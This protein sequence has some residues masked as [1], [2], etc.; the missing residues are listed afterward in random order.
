MRNINR[1]ENFISKVNIRHLLLE[2]WKICDDT[3]VDKIEKNITDNLLKITEEWYLYYDHRF[4]QVLVNLGYIPN[5]PGSWYYYEEGDIL[6][7]QGYKPRDYVFWG[8]IF[9]R[10]GNRL[11]DTKYVLIKDLEISHM[12][13][14]IEGNWLRSDSIYKIISDELM[15][16]SRKE[17][18]KIINSL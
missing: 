3:N 6:S 17:K 7:L 5:M 10:D 13:K 15:I 12:E 4:S 18:L 14:L 8:S 2:V 11:E 1:I 9:D 16:R